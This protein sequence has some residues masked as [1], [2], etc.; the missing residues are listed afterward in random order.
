VDTSKKLEA[1]RVIEAPA[2]DIFALLADPNRHTE[3]DG[4]DTLRGPE[5]DNTPVAGVGQ[6]FTMKM[7]QPDTGDYQTTNKVVAFIPTSRIGWGPILDPSSSLA[8]RLGEIDASGHTYTYDLEEVEGG[9]KV[10]LTL[11]WTGVKDPNFEALFPVV[12]QE[13]LARTLDQIADVVS[14]GGERAAAREVIMADAPAEV[15][16]EMHIQ[17]LFSLRDREGMQIMF[18]L[19]NHESVRDHADA[20]LEQLA[21]GRMPCYGSWP[22]EQIALF[23]HWKEGGMLP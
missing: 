23:R 21:A 7:H 8:E 17:P 16:F 14:A 5:G 12:S 6:A 4:T 15:S 13:Q 3:F 10:T 22:E 2:E 11:D 20:I 9:T 1:S 18:D 19:W